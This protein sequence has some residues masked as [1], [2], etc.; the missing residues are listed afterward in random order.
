MQGGGAALATPA[1]AS[2]QVFLYWLVLTHFLSQVLCW[3]TL[4]S[5]C[6]FSRQPVSLSSVK[7]SRCSRIETV[8]G[9]KK[10]LRRHWCWA[11][12][13]FRVMG[14]ALQQPVFGLEYQSPAPK[15]TKKWAPNLVCYCAHLQSKAFSSIEEVKTKPTNQQTNPPKPTK[16]TKEDPTDRRQERKWPLSTE[17]ECGAWEISSFF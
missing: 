9:G 17:T 7:V 10:P 13:C 5:F 4:K 6:W 12:W 2:E 15:L 8:W 14:L 3:M 16:T 1:R 11:T